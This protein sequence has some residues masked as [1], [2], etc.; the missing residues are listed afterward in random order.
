[1]PFRLPFRCLSAAFSM[2]FLDFS[3]P[4]RCLFTAF[5]LPFHRFPLTSDRLPLTS[6][7]PFRSGG[8]DGSQS[9]W[10]CA[11]GDSEVYTFDLKARLFPPIR[12][13][14]EDS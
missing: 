3:M 5:P 6:D 11:L 14:F 8:G 12:S 7:F 4:F 10:L 1:M 13:I 2:P 9:F